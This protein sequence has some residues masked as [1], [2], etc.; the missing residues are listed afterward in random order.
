MAFI[1]CK[2]TEQEKDKLALLNLKNPLFP[3]KQ[4]E[5]NKLSYQTFDEEQDARLLII[6]HEIIWSMVALFL[7]KE[8]V[9]EIYAHDSADY[10]ID[11]INLKV[12]ITIKWKIDKIHIPECLKNKKDELL[13]LIKE[14]LIVKAKKVYGLEDIKSEIFSVQCNTVF[15][16][17]LELIFY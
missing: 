5:L 16:G 4:I 13:R 6:R 8:N 11:E 9:C 2:L 17:K 14:S 1:N 15:E 10:E 12:I 3:Q 7:W